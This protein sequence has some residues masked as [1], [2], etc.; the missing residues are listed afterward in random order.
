MSLLALG[1]HAASSPPAVSALFRSAVRLAN[2]SHT[3][4]EV[5]G[6]LAHDL[7]AEIRRNEHYLQFAFLTGAELGQ[8]DFLVR[9]LVGSAR[10]YLEDHQIETLTRLYPELVSTWMDQEP[11]LREALS[12]MQAARA[13]GNP[14]L[15]SGSRFKNTLRKTSQKVLIGIAHVLSW[16]GRRE[17][18]AEEIAIHSE[19]RAN[20]SALAVASF[21]H[22]LRSGCALN[23]EWSE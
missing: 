17:T 22:V 15:F 10:E 5:F 18:F 11:G 9:T 4:P 3:H 14:N 21:Y 20:R 6:H 8:D 12:Q 19:E 23:L 16:P 7:R 2:V 1:A 13:T